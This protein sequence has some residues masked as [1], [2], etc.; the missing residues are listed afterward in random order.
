MR[1]ALRDLGGVGADFLIVTLCVI[2]TS[3]TALFDA[4]FCQRAAKFVPG[5]ESQRSLKLT[6]INGIIFV[7]RVM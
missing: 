6:A 1:A 4:T 7:L 3:V 2:H 5:S